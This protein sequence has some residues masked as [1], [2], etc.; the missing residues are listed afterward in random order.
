[1][2][3]MAALA[4]SSHGAEFLW[5]RYPCTGREQGVFLWARYPGTGVVLWVMYPCTGR[6]DQGSVAALALGSHGAPA[7]HRYIP[8]IYII[9]I[10]YIFIYIYI[11]IYITFKYRSIYL[12]IC[13]Y[14]YVYV[15]IYMYYIYKHIYIYLSI[16]P[17][18]PLN[19]LQDGKTCPAWRFSRWAAMGLSP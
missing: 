15:Y 18:N 6:E 8:F 1:M 3:S 17:F 10:I 2:H 7:R 4:L 11:Y 12:S 14:M 19:T 5:S 16:H 9:C 13:K